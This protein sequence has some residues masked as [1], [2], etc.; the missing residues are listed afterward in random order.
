M[1]ECEICGKEVSETRRIRM[2]R[3]ELEVCSEC[4]SLGEEIQR[5]GV[6]VPHHVP[7]GDF[8]PE[9]EEREVVSDLAG[10]VRCAREKLGL[11]QK[12]AASKIGI[13][14]SV[15]RRIE[16]QG[17]RPDDKTL[18]RIEKGLKIHLLK[19]MKD[20]VMDILDG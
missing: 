2:G 20:D 4:S 8:I 16:S 14:E 7:K 1:P 17:F 12:D 13:Q 6:N 15:L 18:R 5:R 19:K 11:R 9:I 10:R 3:S